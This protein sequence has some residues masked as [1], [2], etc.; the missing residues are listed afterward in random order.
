[1]QDQESSKPGNPGEL[2]PAQLARLRDRLLGARAETLAQ[3]RREEG[4]ARAAE[5]L[6]EPMDAAELSREQGDA[7]LL[8]ERHR[9]RLLEIDDALRKLDTGDYG[10]SE[11]SGQPIGYARLEAVPWARLAADEE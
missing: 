1:M 8:V 10:V 6:S 5:R 2:T 11:Q 9:Q 3:L 7:A 4:S